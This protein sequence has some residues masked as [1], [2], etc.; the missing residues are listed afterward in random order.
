[1]EPMTNKGVAEISAQEL[2]SYT[3]STIVKQVLDTMRDELDDHR[4]TIN[5]NTT[6]IETVFEFLNAL[7]AKLDNVQQLVEKL[8]LSLQEPQQQ[9]GV[10]NRREKTVCQALFLLGKTKPWVSCED[11]AKHC[12]ISREVLAA[13]LAG[14]VTKH[15]PVIKKYDSTKA[16]AQL[17][18]S[19]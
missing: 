15:V 1:M 3:E 4:Q 17:T 19:F 12:Q 18:P 7:E 8:A 16:Y 6:E 14:L 11:I 10:L 2:L 5:E 9:I 13:T